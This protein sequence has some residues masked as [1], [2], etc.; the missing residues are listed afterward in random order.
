MNDEPM[1][2]EEKQRLA[3]Q[4]EAEGR[5]PS[6]ADFVNGF[7]RQFVMPVVPACPIILSGP[8]G[9]GKDT[10]IDKWSQ[11]NPRIRKV[12]TYTTRAPREGEVDGVHYHFV[13]KAKFDELVE[14]GAFLEWKEVHGHFYASPLSDTLQLVKDGFFPVL[15]IDVQGA[16][17]AM[18]L[19]P[20]CMSFF[21]A[22]PSMEEL[23]R[24]IRE[25]KSETPEQIEARLATARE[26]MSLQDEYDFVI[27]NDVVEEVIDRLDIIL[28]SRV[29]R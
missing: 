21:I 3:Q 1:S 27:I 12:V 20:G 8:S 17:D 10:I 2:P 7:L 4:L 14:S 25:R 16:M 23:E 9:V 22:P 5:M 26:E 6:R 15:K 24:R 19:L 13:T 18:E 11:A 28:C 29:H